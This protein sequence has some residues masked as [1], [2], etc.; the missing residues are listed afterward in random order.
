MAILLHYALLSAFG[1]MFIEGIHLYRMMTEVRN[2]NQ[3]PMTYYYV[4]AYGVPGL[5]VGLAVP[6]SEADYGQ[7]VN[8]NN[9]HL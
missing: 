2:I 4:F 6:L 1:W 7:Q 3:G 8:V 9:Q 5:I